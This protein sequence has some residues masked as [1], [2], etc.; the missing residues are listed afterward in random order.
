MGGQALQ[1]FR[2]LSRPAWIKHVANPTSLVALPM[3]AQLCLL[4]TPELP[5]ARCLFSLPSQFKLSPLRTATRGV[6]L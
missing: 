4:L 5:S 6:F 1:P 2:L 3:L